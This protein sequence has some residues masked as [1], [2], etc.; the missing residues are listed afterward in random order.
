[1]VAMN[2]LRSK[3]ARRVFLLFVAC[4]FIPLLLMV[5]FSYFQ[6]TRELYRQAAR[7]L[8]VESKT[9][10]M[11]IIEK[12]HFLEAELELTAARLPAPNGDPLPEGNDGRLDR[13]KVRFESVAVMDAA[14][15]H[16]VLFGVPPALVGFEKEALSHLAA[17][18]T[19]FSTRAGEGGNAEIFAVRMLDTNAPG[20]GFLAG[21]VRPA[22]LWGDES[23]WFPQTEL[24][25]FDASG[26]LLMSS[27]P[28][29][30]PLDELRK[31]KTESPAE[32][33]VT[34]RRDGRTYRAN[35]WTVFMPARY[36]V[37]WTLVLAQSEADIL[38]PLAA[39]KRT[40]VTLVPLTL[41]V[42][43]LLSFEQIRRSLIPLELL[44]AAT[45]KLAA[46]DFRAR[47]VIESDDEFEELGRSYNSMADSLERHFR[48]METITGIG[49]ALSAE[50]DARRLMETIVEGSMA[51]LGADAGM[52]YTSAGVERL[53]LSVLHID[54]LDSREN[55][56]SASVPLV[57][58]EGRPN[59]SLVA[60]H[61]A[62]SGKAINVV[63]LYAEEFSA[64]AGNRSFD[65][66]RGYRSRSLL[67]VPMRNHENE[68]IG[69]LQLI[70]AVDRTSGKHVPF[71]DDDVKIAETLA[72]QAA[73][74]LTKIYLVEE[75]RL[76]FGA[77]AELIATAIDEK[78]HYTGGH[79]RR[80]PDLALMLA[81]AVSRSRQG[82]FANVAFTE[83][84][85]YELHVAALLHDCGKVTTPVHIVDKATRLEGIYDRIHLIDFKLEMVKKDLHIALLRKKL[86]ITRNEGGQSFSHGEEELRLILARLEEDRS[87]L[88]E[89]NS[90]E[91]FMTP[92]YQARVREISGRYRY[93]NRK[94]DEENVLSDDEIRNL[95]IPT[96][97]LT[98][99][100]REIVKNHV[101]ITIKML[102]SLP[103][104]KSLRQVPAI[105]AAHHERMDGAGYPAGLSKDDIPLRGRIL[106]LAD[107]FEALTASDRP[108]KRGRTLM[109][110]VR[111]LGAM[112]QQGHVDPGLFA[113]FISEK[114]YLQ[115]A[116]KH[117]ASGQID[118]V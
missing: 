32:R 12:L 50:K 14:G 77:L 6:A 21:K 4:A 70:N 88:H 102:N 95:T 51:I 113:V 26:R 84:D 114:V 112:T 9:S 42:V 38:A 101:T 28:G 78:S 55:R 107:I 96:G 13:T 115:Y 56:G 45:R 110:A 31:A 46:R 104:P 3:V 116:E 39:Y 60:A 11:G 24:W 16:R 90:G 76:L 53:E 81:E 18:K 48:I 41:L 17:G 82:A 10:G 57:D 25:V 69:V 47:V 37:V 44:N 58:G 75:F 66:D 59:S 1:M 64:F 106:A 86:L 23:L 93:V 89:C 80:V 54:S 109:E 74:A 68:I 40:F 91:L 5:S 72:S 103:Y 73:V 99:E 7:R 62:N 19:L 43:L 105:A 65:R 100:E 20:A 79:C 52:V 22:Y 35:Y 67:A 29:T 15:K 63:D 108:Y 94:G 71:T 27:R 33:T 111:V 97:T 87:F 85:L 49:L 98:P 117:L 8:S 83:A 30:A 2:F 34:W 36:G 61:A 118:A 92:E